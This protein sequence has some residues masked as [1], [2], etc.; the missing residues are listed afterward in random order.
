MKDQLHMQKQNKGFSLVELIIAIAILVIV[1]GAVCSF[2]VITSRNYANGNNDIG[3]Q[4]EAQLAF[5][6]ISD[7]VIDARNS[8]NYAGEDG[9]GNFV[10]V[11]KDSEFANTPEVKKLI[12]YNTFTEESE[13]KTPDPSASSVPAASAS[14]STSPGT[15]TADLYNYIFMW[16]KSDESLYFA[17]WKQEET[18]PVSISDFEVLAEHINDFQVD[19]SQVEERRVVKL[20]MNFTVGTRG[21]QMA[22]NVT[23]RNQVVINEADI[24][25]L[26]KEISVEISIRENGLI[27]E[28]GEEY[29]F[30]S[31]QIKSMN[32]KNKEIEWAFTYDGG[33]TI[34]DKTT[35]GSEF[36]DK[37]NG[38][39]KVGID[40]GKGGKPSEFEVVVI[41]KATNGDKSKEAQSLPIKVQIKRV[42][43]VT[44]SKKSEDVEAGYEDKPGTM[45]ALQGSTIT[46]G[47]EAGGN[48]LK[49]S[50]SVCKEDA[51]RDQELTDWKIISGASLVEFGIQSADQT[52]A[53]IKIK[54]DAA[55]GST[56]TIQATSSLSKRKA[57]DNVNGTITLTVKERKS[58]VIPVGGVLQYG[59]KIQ[60][61]KMLKE[62]TTTITHHVIVIRV[63]DNSGKSADQIVAYHNEGWNLWVEPEC[64]NLDLTKAYTFYMQALE[65]VSKE[66][67]KEWKDHGGT[68]QISS[69]EEIWNE[70]IN[71]ISNKAPYGYEGDMFNCSAV[72][73]TTLEPPKIAFTYNNKRYV[74]QNIQIKDYN[75]LTETN[76]EVLG[77]VAF[78]TTQEDS[79]NINI[80]RRVMNTLTYSLYVGEGEDPSQWTKIKTFD[81]KSLQ[82]VYSELNDKYLS[83]FQN[84]YNPKLN[85]KNKNDSNTCGTYHIV[86]GFVFYRKAET[87][88]QIVG[89]QNYDSSYSGPVYYDASNSTIH[90]K[91][92][93]ETTMEVDSS[94][95]RGGVCFPV[96]LEMKSDARFTDILNTDWHYANLSQGIDLH[97][98]ERDTGK[99]ISL[100]I[101]KIRYHR[102][103]GT[104][105]I[106]VEPIVE[107]NRD[108]VLYISISFGIY[109]CDMNG[110]KWERKDAGRETGN[111]TLVFMGDDGKDYLT[112]YPVP[113]DPDFNQ[114]FNVTE[115]KNGNRQERNGETLIGYD[116][117][118]PAYGSRKDMY[119]SKTYCEYVNGIYTLTLL[120]SENVYDGF[121]TIRFVYGVYQCDADGNKWSRIKN[122]D[123]I[124]ETPANL[125]LWSNRNYITYVP[126]P[127][128]TN[129]W[130]SN[131]VY[132]DLVFH[133]T[134][135]MNG[136]DRQQI[137]CTLR[138]SKENGKD[139]LTIMDTAGHITCGK[140]IYNTQLKMWI[141][142]NI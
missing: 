90:V 14:P 107:I 127:T 47:G 8:I 141:S 123:T 68:V 83:F 41:I 132:K 129:Y 108:N 45:E 57:Y 86:P 29:Q 44:L 139:T 53:T 37:K 38:M 33:K 67:Y 51:S 11:L 98:L 88:L 97:A 52:S 34:L 70:Y 54:A 81:A 69:D 24:Q 131:T 25:P 134:D 1:T 27:M 128:D 76:R 77:G 142:S 133:K 118:N 3:V 95:F 35:G 75:L 115:L 116:Y 110:E 99:Q 111:G 43:T 6:Q 117:S 106:E 63:V 89:Q 102:I 114:K 109:Q 19:L 30:A 28:P 140:Y 64:F 87:K 138:Y 74:D 10:K 31:P 7:V 96:P 60:V 82:Y 121:W 23:V 61:D 58:K 100:H 113:K 93:A 103:E 40:E 12:V 66:N 73:C 16:Q 5:N 20:M 39:L 56:I 130:T 135:D 136:N 79:L 126:L 59:N 71:H 105:T 13:G 65:A 48:L 137:S 92:K 32:A 9:S 21:F 104:N 72:Y 17:K 125:Y 4:Q 124:L 15:V 120:K 122:T 85:I 80:S 49:S 101:S 94:V 36:I 2:I 22:N 46:I 84:G 26:D 119:I 78:D 91:I 50:C 62:F 18:E 42:N 55:V 112:Y